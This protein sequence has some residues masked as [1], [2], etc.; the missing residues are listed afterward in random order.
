MKDVSEYRCPEC[1]K[2]VFVV[3]KIWQGL[4]A[5]GTPTGATEENPVVYCED[6]GHWV[7]LW[8]DAKKNGGEEILE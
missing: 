2:S 8:Y 7:G 6:H 3:S 5:D 1:G 4:W